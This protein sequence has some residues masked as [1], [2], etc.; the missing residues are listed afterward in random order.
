MIIGADTKLFLRNNPD[1]NATLTKILKKIP[2]M[3]K[4][5]AF[6]V[7]VEQ[8]TLL[9][10]GVVNISSAAVEEI[11]EIVTEERTWGSGHLLVI[12]STT[13]EEI[14]ELKSNDTRKLREKLVRGEEV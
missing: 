13:T 6:V 11:A 4:W 2:K 12:F 10:C 9:C 1:V 3:S 14:A 8:V 7:E 5:G